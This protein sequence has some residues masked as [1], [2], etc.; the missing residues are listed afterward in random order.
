MHLRPVSQKEKKSLHDR[1]QDI[2]VRDFLD[3]AA[4]GAVAHGWTVMKDAT[5]TCGILRSRVWPGF[6]AFHR[7]NSQIFG[8]FYFGNGVKNTDLP[9]MI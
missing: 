9:F 3:N 8:N 7:A 4:H 1:K 2:Y 6:V 5:H